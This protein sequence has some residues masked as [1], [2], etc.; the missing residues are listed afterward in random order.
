MCWR[1]ARLTTSAAMSP[2]LAAPPNLAKAA[3]KWSC[4]VTPLLGTKPRIG[5]LARRVAAGCDRRLCRVD[6]HARHCPCIDQRLGVG[7]TAQV[8]V[9]VTALR[10]PIQERAQVR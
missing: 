8:I 1:P 2:M 7:G 3:K 6:T 4:P 5:N 10:H 9:Q